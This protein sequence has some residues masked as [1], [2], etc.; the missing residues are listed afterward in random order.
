[1]ATAFVLT[2][3]RGP[4]KFLRH[5]AQL[6][7]QPLEN[8][9]PVS[10][11]VRERRACWAATRSTR[12]RRARSNA[13]SPASRSGERCRCEAAWAASPM[14]IILPRCRRGTV[15]RLDSRTPHLVRGR[16][17][18]AEERALAEDHAVRPVGTAGTNPPDVPEADGTPSARRRHR[19]AC[20][21]ALRPRPRSAP[22]SRRLL[23]DVDQ[24]AATD[25][26]LAAGRELSTAAVMFHAIL[27]E[28]QGLSATETKALELLE[29]I[30]LEVIA[31]LLSETA[32]R[33]RTAIA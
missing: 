26:V 21:R 11:F 2:A 27:A 10:G 7:G 15:A 31:R 32:A 33:K 20:R 23:L 19:R 22:R 13:A 9:S 8:R 17:G 3:R 24:P 5:A 14:R 28:T 4:A 6:L 18:V 29:R 16:D 30:E 12:S 1:M 25:A